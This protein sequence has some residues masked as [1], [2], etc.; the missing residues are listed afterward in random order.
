MF[1]L[2][3]DEYIMMAK[4][5]IRKHTCDPSLLDYDNFIYS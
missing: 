2:E 3:I 5:N 1:H 4:K